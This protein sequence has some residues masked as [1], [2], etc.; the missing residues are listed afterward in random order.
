MKHRKTNHPQTVHRC[1]DLL[2]GECYHGEDECWYKHDD[3]SFIYDAK[4]KAESPV[5]QKASEENQ[6]PEMMKR[7]M[8]LMEIVMSK[9]DTL[10]KSQQ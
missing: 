5:F 4:N 8:D 3:I 1:R 9:V 2:Q 10:E 7:M 6:P